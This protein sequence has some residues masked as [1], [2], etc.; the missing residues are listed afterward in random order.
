MKHLKLA[1]LSASILTLS[2]CQTLDGMITDMR[3]LELPAMSGNANNSEEFIIQGNCAQTEIVPELSGY[4][5]FTSIQNTGEGQLITR[6]HI[7]GIKSTCSYTERAMSVDLELDFEGTLGPQ[8]KA[9]APSK[10]SYAYPFFVAI[11]SPG[12]KILAKEVF[13]AS[14]IFPQGQE[15]KSYTE[16]L[17]QVIPLIDTKQGKK[18]KILVGFQLSQDQLDYNRQILEQQ[19]LA[20]EAAAMAAENA[21][22][23]QQ[24]QIKA[25]K[26]QRAKA[27]ATIDPIDQIIIQRTTGQQ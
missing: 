17:R 15:Y 26:E 10:S 6:A 8:A 19:R 22:K 21:Q 11:T 2:A 23:L 5:E 18:Y 20:E 27:A 16:T 24:S 4:S 1:L 25:I 3:N 14:M 13:S 9:V 12:G 7:S